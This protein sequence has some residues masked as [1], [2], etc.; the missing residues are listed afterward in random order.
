MNRQRV[1]LAGTAL[2][3]G[4]RAEDLSSE[5]RRLLSQLAAELGF[6]CPQHKWSPRGEGPPTHPGLPAGWFAGI[7]HKRE[8]VIVGLADRPFGIDLEIFSPRHAGRLS[9]LISMLPEPTV[10]QAILQAACPQQAF[11]QA[12]TLHEAL[13][14]RCS[15]TR[16]PAS[17]VLDTRLQPLLREE[18]HTQVWQSAQWTFALSGSAPLTMP[19]A[20]DVLLPGTRP[21]ELLRTH[22]PLSG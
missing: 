1:L 14:K 20:P 18:R 11:Y 16:R 21:V 6:D 19:V 7:T 8:R 5:A 4:T 3:A 12:W 13:F 15:Q 10:Q 17:S 2:P 22:P 9:G